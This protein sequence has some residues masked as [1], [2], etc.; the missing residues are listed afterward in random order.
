MSATLVNG[1][2]AQHIDSADRGLQYGDGLF[3]TIACRDGQACWLALHLQR[4][5]QG[6]ERLRLA[7]CCLP[8]A[9]SAITV[10]IAN[11]HARLQSSRRVAFIFMRG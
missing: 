9:S 4:L 7:H 5:Q 6:C 3:E 10:R 8:W 2:A 1:R 11:S